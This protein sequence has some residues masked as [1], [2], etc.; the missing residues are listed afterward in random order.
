MY[1]SGVGRRGARSRSRRCGGVR[2]L[3]P[4]RDVESARR[5]RDL[6]RTRLRLLGRFARLFALFGDGERLRWR[7]EDGVVSRWWW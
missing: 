7:F 1:V 6:E 5:T 4:R 2:A 3:S